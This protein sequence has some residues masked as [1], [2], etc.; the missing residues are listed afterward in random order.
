[1]KKKSKRE[2][3]EAKL[4]E[5]EEKLQQNQGDS[6]TSGDDIYK[7]MSNSLPPVE[8]EDPYKAEYI[9][10]EK[11]QEALSEMM[12]S[13]KIMIDMLMAVKKKKDSEKISG[14]KHQEK[15]VSP[16]SMQD[17][18]LLKQ[19]ITQKQQEL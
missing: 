1:M 3:L 12:P 8:M 16:S 5:Q 9:P 13:Q 2:I 7:Q 17:F 18:L 10:K 11:K 14:K 6:N 15:E 19:M 4:R